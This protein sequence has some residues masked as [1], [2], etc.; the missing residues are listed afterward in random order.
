V[1]DKRFTAHYD[2][3]RGNDVDGVRE[4]SMIDHILVS[5]K[6]AAMIESVDIVHKHDPTKVS[7]HFPVVVTFRT[8]E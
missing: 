3:D 1:P 6:L 7:D 4:L 2:K 5:K 8:S